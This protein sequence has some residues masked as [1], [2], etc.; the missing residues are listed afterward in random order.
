MLAF[1]L[2]LLDTE[3][4]KDK[5]EQ[6]YTRYRG[7]MFHVASSVLHDQYLAEDAVHETFLDLIRII[8]EVRVNNRQ[9][10]T[11]FLKIL[12]YHKAIDLVR[13]Y[14]KHK[15]AD[16]ELEAAIPNH[17]A[18]N[19]ETV[20]FGKLAYENMVKIVQDMDEKY[21]TPLVLKIDGYKISEIA[22]MLQLS[23]GAVKV[24][25]YR[26][27]RMILSGLEE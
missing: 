21:K 24:R 25:L 11:R 20:V 18:D 27:R 26:A 15:K 23:E 6:I 13:K 4:Q 5:L 12:T 9:E 1:Y 16:D 19:V 10:L 17:A 22:G 8:D 2:A 3:E 7:L 14:D